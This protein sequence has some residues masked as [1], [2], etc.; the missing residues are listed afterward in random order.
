MA[1]HN[2]E[3]LGHGIV[4]QTLV[5]C[6]GYLV[7][8]LEQAGIA[9]ALHVIAL[10]IQRPRT[11]GEDVAA[12]FQVHLVADGEVIST[13]GQTE[14]AAGVVHIGRHQE[15]RR[16]AAGEGEEEERH[17]QRQRH[18]LDHQIGRSGHHILLGTHLGVSHLHV[19]VG[20]L[21]IVAGGIFTV[22]HVQFVA[23]ALLGVVARHISFALLAHDVAD[24]TPLALEVVADGIGFI[25]RLPVLEDR[26]A[27]Y[28][29]Q[30]ILHAVGIDGAAVHVHGDDGGCQLGLR[31]GHL[32]FAVQVGV[33]VLREHDGVRGLVDNG[34]VQCTLFGRNRVNGKGI[35]RQRI[36]RLQRIPLASAGMRHVPAPT[37]RFGFS[38]ND[39]QEKQQ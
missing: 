32:T 2:L 23:R 1:P 22:L 9:V 16:I 25:G 31:I 18:V 26:L 3:V 10:R 34:G 35:G 36:A 15:S 24:D 12:H 37:L 4:G 39:Q 20:M 30:R 8:G 11:F 17:R 6:L 14:S 33:A 27:R 28:H 5:A 38:R 13:V 21:V 29:S 7:T 19:E